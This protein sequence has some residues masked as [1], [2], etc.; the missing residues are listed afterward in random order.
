MLKPLA[1]AAVTL[2]AA[3]AAQ[4]APTTDPAGDLLPTYVGPP[5]GDLDVLSLEAIFGGSNFR[6]TARHADDIGTTP[7]G[8]YVWGVD[9]GA[10]Q[11]FFTFGVPSIGA[12]VLFDAVVVAQQDGSAIVVDILAGTPPTALAAGSV[13]IAGPVISIDVP[14][15]LL[16]STGFAPENYTFNLWPRSPGMGN[17][18][19]ADFAPDASNI[20]ATVPEPAAL[21]LFGLALAPLLARRRR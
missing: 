14:L 18:F 3:G 13:A 20:A 19:V 15:S 5:G 17:T 4:A 8:F 9:R 1:L 7:G 2:F 11:P 10:G 12:G 16:P 21:A 6:L